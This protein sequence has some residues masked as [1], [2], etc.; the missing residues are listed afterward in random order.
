MSITARLGIQ[1]A[2]AFLLG[3]ELFGA[4]YVTKF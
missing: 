3:A 1:C 2:K 4:Q